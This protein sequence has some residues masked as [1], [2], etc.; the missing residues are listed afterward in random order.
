VTAFA[1][2]YVHLDVVHLSVNVVG[3]LLVVP[4][5]YLLSVASGRRRRF[6]VTFVTLLVAFPVALSYMN[7]LFVRPTVGVGF[8]G[9]LLAFFGYVPLALGEFLEARFEIR[10]RWAVSPVLFFAGFAL[11]AP[12]SVR[13]VTADRATVYLG[14]AGLVLATVLSAVLFLLHAVEETDDPWR[15]IRRSTAY[16]G[17]FELGVVSTALFVTFPVV[18]FPADPI[19]TGGIVN[20]YLHLL[21][22]A[23]GFMAAYATAEAER[24]LQSR[25]RFRPAS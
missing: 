9:V 1:S 5:A 16:T 6:F 11:I 2:A 7:L 12:L 25:G 19:A 23:L 8:S 15:K 20:L 24:V 21:G 10:P 17:Y 22:Y 3:Y 18:A 14:T 13:S 4:A